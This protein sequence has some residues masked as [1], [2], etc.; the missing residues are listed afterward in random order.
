MKNIKKIMAGV[1]VL[2]M[3]LCFCACGGNGD[4]GTTTTTESTTESTT[5]QQT[6]FK[7][8]VVDEAG[9]P[10][11]GVMVQI[12]KDSCVPAMTDAE[13]VATFTNME[14]TDGHKLSVMTCPAG[15]EYTGEAEIYLES[16]I[17]EY[18]LEIKAVA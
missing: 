6:A 8:K 11:A 13:G 16:G 4:D 18:T 12:C 17:T 10:V 3:M 9:N 15:Y 14:I 5:V 7:V 2:C 1:L